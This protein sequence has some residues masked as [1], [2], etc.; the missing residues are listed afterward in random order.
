[1]LRCIDNLNSQRIR[2]DHAVEI[3]SS[4]VII[5]HKSNASGLELRN[6]PAITLASQ[7]VAS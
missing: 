5:L 4:A 2:M 7:L 6:R 1:M 3:A